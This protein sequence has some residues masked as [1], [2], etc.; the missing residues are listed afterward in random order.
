[1]INSRIINN[2]KFELI[3]LYNCE[4]IAFIFQLYNITIHFSL[5]VEPFELLCCVHTIKAICSSNLCWPALFCCA[6]KS[7]L[8][9]F[10][11]GFL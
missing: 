6:E 11:K 3:H 7:L 10:S 1:M 9:T 4:F 8:A 2:T 5:L